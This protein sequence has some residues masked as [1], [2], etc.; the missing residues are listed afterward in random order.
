MFGTFLCGFLIGM[1]FA[2]FVYKNH[3]KLQ[4]GEKYSFIVVDSKVYKL[5]EIDQPSGSATT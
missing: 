5:V 4:R 2:S 1:V 3:F